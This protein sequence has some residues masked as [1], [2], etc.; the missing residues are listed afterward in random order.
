MLVVCA[1]FVCLWAEFG[2]TV[3]A[4]VG[5]SLVEAQSNELA[6]NKMQYTSD[7]KY[8]VQKSSQPPVENISAKNMHPLVS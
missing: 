1:G 2:A 5:S 6:N 7:V 3:L 4:F 8:F